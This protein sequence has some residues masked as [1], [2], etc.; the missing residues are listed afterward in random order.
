MFPGDQRAQPE[1]L[2]HHYTAAG[3]I[4][5]AIPTGRK[6]AEEPSS[7][8]PTQKAIS[9][10]TR[11]LELLKVLPDTEGAPSKELTLHL[12][13]G[14]TYSTKGYGAPEV[15]KAYA[16]AFEL[17]RQSRETPY[18]LQAQQGLAAFYSMRG[19]FQIWASP[20]GRA[21]PFL[22]QQMGDP[23]R[24]L[25]AQW[26]LGQTLFHIGEFLSAREHVE[27]ALALYDPA[28]TGPAL[29]KTSE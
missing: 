23:S 24:L 6:R 19:Q 21:V 27:H 9:H 20:V 4:G 2:A 8:R 28:H 3:R 22:A 13:L 10:L 17:C 14:A 7:A 1:L 18:L 26:T 16:R 15:E 5:E 29:Y 25:Q 12:A 11:G